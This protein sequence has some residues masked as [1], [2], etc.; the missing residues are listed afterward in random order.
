FA[1]FIVF[2]NHFGFIVAFSQASFRKDYAS[3]IHN[4]GLLGVS[5]FF[6]LSGF[7]LAWSARAADTTGLFW[8]RRVFKI[9]PLHLVMFAAVLIEY[10]WFATAVSDVS[11]TGK[12]L[13]LFMVQTWWPRTNFMVLVNIPSWTLSC[14]L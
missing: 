11:W 7:V 8:R 6:V 14:E 13:N 2:L 1:A 5:F 12:I 10:T 9:F 3:V 4:T